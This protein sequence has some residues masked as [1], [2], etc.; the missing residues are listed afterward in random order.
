MNEVLWFLV[1]MFGSVICLLILIGGIVYMVE[2][3]EK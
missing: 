2:G 1:G 3:G